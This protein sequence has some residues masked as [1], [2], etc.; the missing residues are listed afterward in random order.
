MNENHGNGRKST[1]FDPGQNGLFLE[2]S[3][4]F[5]AT[6]KPKRFISGSNFCFLKAA[7]K[8]QNVEIVCNKCFFFQNS[9]P[10]CFIVFLEMY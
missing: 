6:G 7:L 10:S 8:K 3:R 1:G 2:H 4:R 5:S 9:R